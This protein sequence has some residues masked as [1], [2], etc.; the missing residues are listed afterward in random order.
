MSGGIAY[1]YDQDK[2]FERKC[3]LST[4]DLEKIKI[5]EDEAELKELIENH[6]K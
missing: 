5:K 2:T 1:I 3:N 6:F 4:F